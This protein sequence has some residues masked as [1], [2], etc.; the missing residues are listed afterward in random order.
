M[1]VYVLVYLDMHLHGI[2]I[3]GEVALK[4]YNLAYPNTTV[5]SYL[6]TYY[7]LKYTTAHV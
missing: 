1:H 5:T 4:F 2:Y 7:F 3:Q 6:A